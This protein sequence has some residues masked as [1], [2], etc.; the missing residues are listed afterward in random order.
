MVQL[1]TNTP[2]GHKLVEERKEERKGLRKK[3]RLEKVTYWELIGDL[4]T[5]MDVG[6]EFENETF[7]DDLEYFIHKKIRD[8]S[9]SLAFYEL[10][11]SDALKLKFEK[12]YLKKGLEYFKIMRSN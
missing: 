6:A 9:F 8:D 2:V 7:L 4:I 10:N 12:A 1:Y 5:E 3:L 11:R